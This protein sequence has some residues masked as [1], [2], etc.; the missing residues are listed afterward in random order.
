MLQNTELR[1]KYEHDVGAARKAVMALE[2]KLSAE[3]NAMAV[4]ETRVAS[5]TLESKKAQSQLQELQ[6][7]YLALEG[8]VGLEGASWSF[9]LPLYCNLIYV[10]Q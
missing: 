7:T 4:V 3:K 1:E 2:S 10:P 5:L 9:G 8:E 6:A